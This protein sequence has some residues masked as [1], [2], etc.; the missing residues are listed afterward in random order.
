MEPHELRQMFA[1]E[2]SHWWYRALRRRISALLEQSGVLARSDDPTPRGGALAQPRLLDAGCGTGMLLTVL[3]ARVTGTGLDT[4][5]LALALAQRRRPGRLVRASV[6]ALPVR[7]ASQTIVVSA[8]VL[9]HRDVRDDVAALR[10]MAR[11][12]APG[13]VLVLN[14]PAFGTLR[15]V[16]DDAVHGA[17]RYTVREVRVKLSAVGLAPLSVRYWNW[18]LFPPI[19]AARFCRRR[20]RPCWESAPATSGAAAAPA[21]SDLVP[22]PRWLN[23]LLDGLMR[24]EEKAGGISPFAGLSVL[25]LAQKRGPRPDEASQVRGDRA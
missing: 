9:Y 18:I 15:S 23:A 19:A 6:E 7:S 1:L 21:H 11:C 4:S 16:H 13:G 22:L 12:L 24:L 8:D 25:A 10:E 14:L 5:E 2:E 3:D 20:P 17:R